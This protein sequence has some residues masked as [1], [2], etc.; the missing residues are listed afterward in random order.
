MARR[1]FTVIIRTRDRRVY[2]EQCVESVLEQTRRPEQVIVVNDGS[3]DGTVELLRGRFPQVVV[4]EQEN[5]GRSVALNHGLALAAHDWVCLLDDDDL[6]HREKLEEVERYL[7]LHEDCR[8]LNHP[9][10]FFRADDAAPE[11]AAQGFLTDFYASSLAECHAAVEGDPPSQNDQSFL[12]IRGDSYRLLLERNRGSYSASVVRKDVL[13]S[14]GALPPALGYGEDWLFFLNVA[15]LTE[16]HTLPRR[17]GFYRV[18]ATQSTTELGSATALLAAHLG[19]WF[20]GRT[21]PEERSRAEWRAALAS[22]QPHYRWYVQQCLWDAIRGRRLRAALEI[23]RLG[24]PLIQGPGN[25]LFVHVPPQL[26]YRLRR[27]RSRRLT[28][29]GEQ[30][31]S[32]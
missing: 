23:R 13:L 26:T 2:V 10:W 24:R 8:A 29:R 1:S 15:R 18:H 21:F 5:R 31:G 3:T 19:V 27:L 30:R 9:L 12:E 4:L 25:W 16:W 11:K 20:G 6:W 22:Y 28:V 14:A 32:S 17:L 7:D